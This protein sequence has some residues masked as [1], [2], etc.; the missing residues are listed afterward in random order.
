MEKQDRR[1]AF[2]R[3]VFL[4]GLS[5]VAEKHGLDMATDIDIDLD[6]F[7]ISITKDME[8]YEKINLIA[9]IEEI[10]GGLSD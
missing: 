4:S 3:N 9:D 5:L 1:N 6:S 2:D 10:S 8:L 7:T